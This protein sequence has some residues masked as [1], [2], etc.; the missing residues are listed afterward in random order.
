M[1]LDADEIE[2]R[3]A[4]ERRGRRLLAKLDAGRLDRV[5]ALL[6]TMKL[7]R[8]KNQ[9][10]RSEGIEVS[11]TEEIFIRALAQLALND[12]IDQTEEVTLASFRRFMGSSPPAPDGSFNAGAL[13]TLWALC[14]LSLGLPTAMRSARLMTHERFFSIAR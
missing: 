5:K 3:A 13:V 12:I 11:E 7:W 2:K 4:W 10:L 1:N 14:R 9:L 8:A 6:Q